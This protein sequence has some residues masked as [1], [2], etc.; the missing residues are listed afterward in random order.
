M[1]SFAQYFWCRKNLA[2]VKSRA[3]E[4]SVGASILKGPLYGVV[5]TNASVLDALGALST[6]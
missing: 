1:M 4:T 6:A 3:M 2:I 5:K